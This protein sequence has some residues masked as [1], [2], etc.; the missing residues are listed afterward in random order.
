M[1]IRKLRGFL[2]E[3]AVLGRGVFGFYRVYPGHLVRTRPADIAGVEY[4]EAT[5]VILATRADPPTSTNVVGCH[6]GGE[7]RKE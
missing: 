2:G 6:G 1:E 3:R 7:R 5:F 4:R